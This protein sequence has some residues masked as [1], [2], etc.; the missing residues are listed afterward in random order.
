MSHLRTYRAIL[1]PNFIARQNRSMQLRMLHT[2][3][4]RITNVASNDSADD[5]LRSRLV[6]VSFSLHI[7]SVRS[8]ERKH[9]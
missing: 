8:L 5:I 2:D 7:K 3:A 9:M 6:L 1:S 4:N